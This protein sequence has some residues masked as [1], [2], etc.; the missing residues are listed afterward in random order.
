M[1]P[2]RTVLTYIV[3]AGMTTLLASGPRN[4]PDFLSSTFAARA[5]NT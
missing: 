5:T 1:A 4:H 3:L 2:S